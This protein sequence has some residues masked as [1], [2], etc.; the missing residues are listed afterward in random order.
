MGSGIFP[1]LTQAASVER[2]HKIP[3]IREELGGRNWVAKP[4]I[5]FKAAERKQLC[6]QDIALPLAL[7]LGM[8]TLPWSERRNP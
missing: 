7:S 6:R 3:Q 8:C 4:H 2:V 1:T 5:R